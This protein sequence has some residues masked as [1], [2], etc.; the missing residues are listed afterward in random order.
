MIYDVEHVHHHDDGDLIDPPGV[1]WVS[2]KKTSIK[3]GGHQFEA[4]KK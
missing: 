2:P 3:I 1:E 4:D